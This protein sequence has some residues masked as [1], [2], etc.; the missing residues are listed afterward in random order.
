M[1]KSCQKLSL[2]IL[3][4]ISLS[5]CFEGDISRQADSSKTT[6]RDIVTSRE[7][8]QPGGS[9]FGEGGLSFDLF[10]SKKTSPGA[11]TGLG[12]NSFLWRATL[13]TLNFMPIISADPFGG[14]I[15]TDWYS[16]PGKE[17]ERFK[18]NAFVLDK[19][20]R[21]DA[22]R[23]GL[24]RQVSGESGQ[25]VDAEPSRDSAPKL[26][27]AILTKARQLRI[28]AQQAAQ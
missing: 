4:M 23:I 16:A 2:T 19:E 24:F 10:N 11:G 1:V 5:G 13:E 21:A 25:W 28:A 27:E 3:M 20:L 15:I 9:I 12:V 14:V 26:E 8:R 17:Q 18:I 6:V 22:V 7:D